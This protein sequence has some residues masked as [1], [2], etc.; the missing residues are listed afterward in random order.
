MPLQKLV[1]L[2]Q[3]QVQADLVRQ[4]PGAAAHDGRYDEQ[5]VSS[6]SPAAMAWRASRAPPTVRSTA[7]RSFSLRNWTGLKSRSM[8]VLA[9][10]GAWSVAGPPRPVPGRT[11]RAKAEI[12]ITPSVGPGRR[13]RLAGV[14]GPGRGA[15][16]V[17]PGGGA[18]DGRWARRSRLIVRHDG[19]LSFSACAVSASRSDRGEA[20]VPLRGDLGHRP[21][22]LV[23]A[24]GSCV[25]M[26]VTVSRGAWSGGPGTHPSRPCAR[27]RS[28]ASPRRAMPAVRGRFR[29]RAGGSVR[30]PQASA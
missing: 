23:E 19:L 16:P 27:P 11:L 20:P 21:G 7:G 29:S 18:V 2:G 14:R 30:R 13:R 17:R 15:C 9:V 3:G 22:G 10:S 28:A 6:T 8:R 5:L 25:V 26:S 4:G 12:V 24:V 1:L